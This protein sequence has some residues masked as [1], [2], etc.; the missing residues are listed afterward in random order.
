MPS[1]HHDLREEGDD[2]RVPS[3]VAAV[4]DRRYFVD[5][6]KKPALIERR[7]SKSCALYERRRWDPPAFFTASRLTTPMHDDTVAPGCEDFCENLP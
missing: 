4:Y 3:S 6:R 5:S 7:Y 2:A 1:S